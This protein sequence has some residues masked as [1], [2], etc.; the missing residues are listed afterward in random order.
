MN[1]TS[2]TDRLMTI[3][4]QAVRVSDRLIHQSELMFYEDNPRIYTIVNRAADRPSQLEIEQRL[5]DMDHVK[6]LIQAIKSNG[7]LIDP[8]IVRGGDN[9]VL[10]GNSRLAAYRAL[11]RLDPIKWGKV[12]VTLLPSDV[13]ESLV[14]TLLGQY[15]IIGRKDWAPYEQAGYLY[16]RVTEHNV[17]PQRVAREMGMPVRT[18]NHLLEVFGFMVHHGE[19]DVSRWSYYEEYFKPRVSKRARERHPELDQVVVEKI[20]S[21][22]IESAVAVR[23]KLIKVLKGGDKSINILKSG[24]DTLERALRSATDRGVDN[25][26]LGKLSGFRSALAD[27][28]T[29]TKFREMSPEQRD[30]ARFYVDKIEVLLRRLRQELD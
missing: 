9:V 13:S 20:G 14:F 24:P 16:R 6:K 29:A 26:W 25:S 7:G 8:L 15:H 21:G 3:G 5:L 18:V 10:E 19:D 27:D 2:G 23:D 4:G 28:S 17:T 11:A 22:E 12:K 1:S 30:K